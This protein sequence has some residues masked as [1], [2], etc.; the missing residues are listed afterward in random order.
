MYRRHW[1]L[2]GLVHGDDFVF[3]GAAKHLAG[4]A[5]HLG[6]KFEVKMKV[7]GKKDTDEL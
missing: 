2:C 3:T 4:I 7:A 6:R 5:E 1:G